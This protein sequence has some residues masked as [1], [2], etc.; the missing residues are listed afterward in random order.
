M[1][2]K[3]SFIYAPQRSRAIQRRD[4]TASP[5]RYLRALQRLF[6][7]L[8]EGV[9]LYHEG[10]VPA[11]LALRDVWKNRVAVVNFLLWRRSMRL[12]ERRKR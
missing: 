8:V 10:D 3:R 6:Y 7:V 4:V 2:A 9:R 11:E 5:V 1:S 12:A